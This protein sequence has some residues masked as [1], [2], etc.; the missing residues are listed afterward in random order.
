MTG[1]S[2]LT[3]QE[4]KLEQDPSYRQEVV[5]NILE[6]AREG[7]VVVDGRCRRLLTAYADGLIDCV[8]LHHEIGRPVLH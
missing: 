5:D 6:A 2:E 3:A 7:G 4:A 8:K 1:L